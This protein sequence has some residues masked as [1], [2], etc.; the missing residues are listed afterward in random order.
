VDR[1]LCRDSADPTPLR[2]P[3]TEHD[4]HVGGGKRCNHEPG[5]GV[6]LHAESPNMVPSRSSP[7]FR[8]FSACR[9]K[10]RRCFQGGRTPAPSTNVM[11]D[12]RC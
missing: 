9:A 3:P 7:I 5:P 12:I 2:N 6:F 1:M 10:M 8:D 11:T 4:G